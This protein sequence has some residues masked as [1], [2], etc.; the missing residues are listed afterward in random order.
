MLDA[1]IISDLHVGSAVCQARSLLEFLHGLRG[2]TRKLIL[3]GDVFDSIDFR[4]LN[5]HHWR[6]LSQLRK[7]SADLE[8]VWLRG[9]H[10][11]NADIVSHLLGVPVLDQYLF[12][13][14]GLQILCLHGDIFDEFLSKRPLLTWLGDVLYGLLQRFDRTHY[15]A[16]VAKQSSKTFLR[17]ADL[18]RE[19]ALDL[20][21]DLGADR[22]CCGHTHHPVAG[23]WY[24]NSGSWAERPC[25]FLTVQEGEIQLESFEETKTATPRCS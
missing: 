21:E 9:N 14:G 1:V 13:S 20:M 18:V 11:G 24:F 17:C 5:K 15:W 19:R 4:R 12:E 8:V 3:N 2:Q 25:T 7:L 10:D 22:V 23:L 16:R 6:V